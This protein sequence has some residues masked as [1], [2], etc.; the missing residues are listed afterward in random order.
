MVYEIDGNKVIFEP[1]EGWRC[2]CL[3]FSESCCEH[4]LRAARLHTIERERKAAGKH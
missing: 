3:D 2:E 1:G 4:S